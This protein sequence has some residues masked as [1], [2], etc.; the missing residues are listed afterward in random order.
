MS[1]DFNEK[2]E[3]K[4]K[5]YCERNSINE[6]DL[7]GKIEEKYSELEENGELF[8]EG[9]P[10]KTHDLRMA[11]AIRAGQGSFRRFIRNLR[12]AKPGVLIC[13]HRD[14]G[15]DQFQV[16]KAKKYSDDN[17]IAKAIADGYMDKD[18]HPL[19][20]SGP[21]KGQPVPKP[22]SYTRITG[23]VTTEDNK[24]NKV[25]DLRCFSVGENVIHKKIPMC[26]HIRISYGDGTKKAKDYP[27]TEEPLLFYNDSGIINEQAGPYGEEDLAEIL[28]V[29]NSLFDDLHF[30]ST[31]ADLS[32][33]KDKH[34]YDMQAKNKEEMFT[35]C[36]VPA[37]CAEIYIDPEYEDK[38]YQDYS[39][40]ITMLEA[41]GDMHDLTCYVSHDAI[42]GLHLEEGLQGI[43][44][45]QAYK[46]KTD[47]YTKWHLGGFLPI[48][49]D[50]VVEEYFA[51]TEEDASDV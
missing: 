17:G 19:Y 1:L 45:M 14:V 20:T 29:W 33:F 4:I 30:C 3:R 13:R 27:Y 51:P 36:T 21:N 22:E 50:I 31:F 28:E 11:R 18:G 42:Q 43:A 26:E 5:D 47:S 10:E 2:Q 15:F 48:S 39:V 24:G 34:C 35:F 12:N 37:M 46:T 44:V 49:D 9:D 40:T 41:N 25:H 7:I 6:D 8:Y 16:N 38:T 23:Y 32:D